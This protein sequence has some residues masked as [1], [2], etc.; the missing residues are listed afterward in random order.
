MHGTSAQQAKNLASPVLSEASS[1]EQEWGKFLPKDLACF[2]YN[3]TTSQQY[4]PLKKEQALKEGFQWKDEDEKI[5]QPQRLKVP[6]HVKDFTD[7]MLNE[8]LSCEDCHKNFKIVA[9]ELK[10]YRKMDIPSPRI[11][12]ECR[13]KKRMQIRNPRQLFERICSN[14]SKK[15][16]STY[17]P[18]RPET[19]LCEECYL[20]EVY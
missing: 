5:S 19:V 20:K 7:G 12:S 9:Q 4:Y 3:E 17:A 2:G 8:I 10:F 18:D 14:C 15:L 1:Y 16:Q 13:H 6:D 11:C